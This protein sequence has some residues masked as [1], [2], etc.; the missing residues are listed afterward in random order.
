M[1]PGRSVQRVACAFLVAILSSAVPAAAAV[2]LGQQV[3]VTLSDPSGAVVPAFSFQDLITAG[4]GVE[5]EPLNGTNIGD[6]A[7]D[8][9]LLLLAN[10]KADIQ[11]SSIIVALEAGGDNGTTGYGPGSSWS[12]AF[13]PLVEIL[14]VQLL[15]LGNVSGVSLGSELIFTEHSVTLF[16]DTL[17]IPQVLEECGFAACGTVDIGLTV[18][19]VPEPAT[20]AMLALGLAGLL[21]LRRRLV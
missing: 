2:L 15:G 4:E 13:G 17:T 10:E 8:G 5:I 14:D 21:V 3:S 11:D 7:I 1:F 20:A 6:A 18:R 9:N 19:V 16:I 12:F